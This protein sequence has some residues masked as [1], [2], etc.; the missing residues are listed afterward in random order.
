VVTHNESLSI[1]DYYTVWEGDRAVYRPT[2]HYAYHPC[3]DAILSLHE[4]NGA[5]QIPEK[6]HILTAEEITGGG[7][8]L[9]VFLYGHAKGAMWY[10][11][12]LTIDE[13][14]AL[15]PYQNATGMQVTS[16]V[17]AAMV[18]VAENPNAGWVEADE[19]DHER[20]LAVQ[21]PYLG[22]VECHYTDWT[23]IQHRINSFAEDRDDDDP[24][25]FT[26][27]LAV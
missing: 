19:M 6:K 13:A 1:P 15:A 20:C 21:R 16:A 10:G 11:S 9:G 17:L 2:C 4:I 23:P 14:R 5:G 18:W 22:R 3:N 26:N 12:R 8:D 27:F 7:D 24:W 25:Q